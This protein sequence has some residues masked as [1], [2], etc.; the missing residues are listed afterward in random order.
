MLVNINDKIVKSLII[1]HAFVT[2]VKFRKKD[3]AGIVQSGKG[4]I[5]HAGRSEPAVRSIS[6]VIVQF[7]ILADLADYPVF[8]TDCYKQIIRNP[9]I[10][11]ITEI[12]LY[13]RIA[14]YIRAD[15]TGLVRVKQ[16]RLAVITNIARNGSAE[17]LDYGGGNKTFIRGKHVACDRARFYR[18][19]RFDIVAFPRFNQRVRAVYARDKPAVYIAFF[20]RADVKHKPPAC[21]YIIRMCL[22]RIITIAYGDKG[23]FPQ[24]YKSRSVIGTQHI[25]VQTNTH[26]NA[27]GNDNM[28]R[29]IRSQIV[30]SA[31]RQI[32]FPV[33]KRR[34][35]KRYIIVMEV[36][37]EKPQFTVFRKEHLR[38]RRA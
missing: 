35:Y 6:G 24:R 3:L 8:R 19:R 32:V 13:D 29:D 28:P 33:R 5:V 20:V 7:R 23:V 34:A 17:Q 26:R 16:P 30:V 18:K 1:Y 15:V 27:V 4:H 11:D 2:S 38:C 14:F 36:P 37:L 31:F 21:V 25:P 12:I 10:I 9:S 22:R